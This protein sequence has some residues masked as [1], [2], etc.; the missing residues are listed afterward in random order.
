MQIWPIQCLIVNIADSKP[1]VV[2]IYKGPKKSYSIHVFFH[3]LIDNILKAIDNG[4]L[5]LQKKFQWNYE[6]SLQ[7]HLH[8]LGY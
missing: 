3:Q 2:G 8:V 1:E 4:V 5:F 6:S 7:M